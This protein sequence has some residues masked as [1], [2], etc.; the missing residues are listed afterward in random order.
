MFFT[1]F[2]ATDWCVSYPP[3]LFLLNVPDSLTKEDFF[4][5][6]HAR[7][8]TRYTV[9]VLCCFGKKQFAVFLLFSLLF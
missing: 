9:P 5:A 3:T 6:S 7:A 4:F 1:T 8:R 2:F